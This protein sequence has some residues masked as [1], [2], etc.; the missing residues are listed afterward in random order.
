MSELLALTDV[1]KSY[2]RGSQDLRVLQ[3][4]SLE[5]GIGEVVCVLGSRG[6]GKTTLLRI[7][8]GMESADAGLVSFDGQ[9]LAALSDRE[10]SH[11]LGTRIAWAGKNGPGLQIQMLDY[12]EL[13][14]LARNRGRGQLWSW[15]RRGLKRRGSTA[16]LDARALAALERVGAAGCAN[17]LWESM[18]DW[19]RALVEIAQAI[20]GEPAL[21]LVDDVTDALG[22]RETDELTALL[23][24]LSRELRMGVL[25]S[26]SDPQA[27]LL[28]DQIMT[29]AG[30]RLTRATQSPPGNVI[31]FPDVSASRRDAERGSIS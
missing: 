23:R 5:V 21:L 27:T 24:S 29:L 28:S 9:N 15:M 14:L 1:A 25:M 8:A 11:L 7:A 3:G 22:I 6:Q 18:S 13:P 2:R 19:E 4:A 20:A 26:V 16:T 31:E 17:Q 10:L 30:G 12:V